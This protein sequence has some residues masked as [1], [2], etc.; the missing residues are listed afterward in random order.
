MSEKSRN[1]FDAPS[2][3]DFTED[4]S[5]DVADLPEDKVP[6]IKQEQIDNVIELIE[7]IGSSFAE[8]IEG[9]LGI[10]DK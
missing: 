2:T 1:E 8:M 6:P 4:Y 7:S 3:D 5:F 9:I 10:G